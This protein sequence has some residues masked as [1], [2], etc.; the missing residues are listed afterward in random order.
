MADMTVKM[1][2]QTRPA[3]YTPRCNRPELGIQKGDVISCDAFGCFQVTDGEDDINPYFVVELPD[4]RCTYVAPEDLRFTDN[5]YYHC[6]KKFA[7]A[8]V[9]EK[10]RKEVI[11]NDFFSD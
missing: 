6:E 11:N 8:P 2:L 9:D 10:L 7:Y 3:I 5:A 1:H 4:G